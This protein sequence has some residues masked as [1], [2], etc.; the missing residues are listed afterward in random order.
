MSKCPECPATLIE[1]EGTYESYPQSPIGCRCE[2][3]PQS[4]GYNDGRR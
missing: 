4:S 3:Y 2:S 1:K